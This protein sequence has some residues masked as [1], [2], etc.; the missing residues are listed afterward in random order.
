MMLPE[1]NAHGAPAIDDASARILRSA[2]EAFLRSGFDGTS[3]DRI[4]AAAK[5]SKRTI[6]ARHADKAALFRAVVND[7]IAKWRGSIRTFC[8][9]DADLRTCLETLA[10]YLTAC[11]LQPASIDVQRLVIA[12]SH[13]WPDL[14]NCFI[15]STCRPAI[16]LIE[17]VLMLHRTELRQID[18]GLAAEHFF[19]LTVERYIVYAQLAQQV[20]DAE[21]ARKTRASVDIFLRGIQTSGLPAT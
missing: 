14:G 10:R 15:E 19:G 4:A 2:A 7:R 3:V 21:I 8:A 1:D 12:E 5:A 18:T 11:W 9:P 20:T 16:D 13:R 17:R 6:Y